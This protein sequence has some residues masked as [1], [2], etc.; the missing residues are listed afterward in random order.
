MEDVRNAEETP[1]TENLMILRNVTYLAQ[2]LD[3]LFSFCYG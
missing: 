2:V 3:G 1:C